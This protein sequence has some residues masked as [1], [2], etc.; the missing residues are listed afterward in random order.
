MPRPRAA[1]LAVGPLCAHG[2]AAVKGGARG[3]AARHAVGPVASGQRERAAGQQRGADDGAVRHGG[4]LPAQGHHRQRRR[5]QERGEPWVALGFARA[6]AHAALASAT[7]EWPSRVAR[8]NAPNQWI[9]P[10]PSSA[11]PQTDWTIWATLRDH[12][13]RTFYYRTGNSPQWQAVYLPKADWA[14][15]LAAGRLKAT[16]LRPLPWAVDETARFTVPGI[17]D[18]LL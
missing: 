15:L 8:R 11:Q 16:P 13:Q 3:L 6:P 10:P 9:L 4:G 18:G 2:H 7:D 12:T 5:R 17:L 14:A 1:A